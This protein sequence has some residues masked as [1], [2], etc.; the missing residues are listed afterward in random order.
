M[1]IATHSVF[2]SPKTFMHL[3]LGNG[4]LVVLIVAFLLLAGLSGAGRAVFTSPG[5]AHDRPA[6]STASVTGAQ[7]S[8]EG[9]ASAE[10]GISTNDTPRWRSDIM[11]SYESVPSLAALAQPRDTQ[12]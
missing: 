10:H 3:T 9:S 8:R 1:F 12:H 4:L 6:V 7:V 2:R 11:D 5:N